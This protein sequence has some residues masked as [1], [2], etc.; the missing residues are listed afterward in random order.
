MKTSLLEAKE[1]IVSTK[2][3]LKIWSAI[4]TLSFE[5]KNLDNFYSQS[6]QFNSKRCQNLVG[7]LSD[8]INA[9]FTQLIQ[10]INNELEKINISIRAKNPW[11]IKQTNKPSLLNKIFRRGYF[12]RNF[13][14]KKIK[15]YLNNDLS[16]DK[17]KNFIQKKNFWSLLSYGIIRLPWKNKIEFTKSWG[18]QLSLLH[19]MNQVEKLIKTFAEE[20]D[21]EKIL[22]EIIDLSKKIII[23]QNVTSEINKINVILQSFKDIMLV[24]WEKLEILEKGINNCL[25]EKNKLISAHLIMLASTSKMNPKDFGRALKAF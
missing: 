1:K 7:E 24:T 12:S 11:F 6:N 18:E 4:L 19:I 3:K 5:E 13:T 9:E 14:I 25:N 23:Y 15:A 22:R 2:E 10:K 17:F 16:F 21:Q 8:S 20:Q